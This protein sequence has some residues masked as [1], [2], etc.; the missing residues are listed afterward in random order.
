MTM[1]AICYLIILVAC[2]LQHIELLTD[3]QVKRFCAWLI[4]YVGV[5]LYVKFAIGVR[6]GK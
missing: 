3:L 2:I 6:R 1:A 5:Y 4:V